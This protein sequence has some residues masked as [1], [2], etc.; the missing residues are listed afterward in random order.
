MTISN[1]DEKFQELAS[2]LGGEFYTDTVQRLLYATDASIFREVPLAIACPRT[3]EDLK[4]LIGFASENELSLIPRAAGTSLAG[5]VVGSGIVVDI[6]R[7]FNRILDFNPE[8]RWVDVEPGVVLDELNLFLKPHGLF[9]GPETSTSNRC[10]IGGMVA[11]N[12]CGAHSIIYGSTREH[13]LEVEAI[14]SD[15]SEARFKEL[16][17]NE[18]IEKR[19][20]NNLEGTIYRH[21]LELLSEPRNQESIRE[22]YPDP[23]VK[24]RNTGYALDLLLDTQP[25]DKSDKPFN[26]SALIAGSEGTLAFITSVR[27]NLVPLPPPVKGLVCPHFVSRE[28]AF[29]ANLIALTYKPG[30][31]EMMDHFILDC[32]KENLEQQRNRF[33]IKGDPAAVLIIEF[34][35]HSDVELARQMGQMEEEMR[36]A[37][38]GYHFPRIFGSDMEKVWDLRRAGLGVL[39]N[40]EGD[41]RPVSLIEDTA[42]NPVVLPSYMREFEEILARYDKECVYHAHIGSGEL[43]LRPVLNLRDPAEVEIAHQLGREVALLV[44]KYRGSLSGEHGD[45]RLRGEFIP[46]VLGERNYDLLRSVKHVFDPKNIFNPGKIIDTPS[47]KESLRVVP[48]TVPREICTY[49]RFDDEDGILRAVEKCNGSGD[50]RK[51]EL[52]GGTMCPSFM[53]TRD[54]NTTTRARANL[55]REFLSHSEKKNPF[56]HKELYDILDLCLSCKGCKSECP[57][58]V[59][60]AK[61][62]SEFLQNWYEVHGIPL[63][64]RLVAGIRRINQL[65]S[66]FPWAYNRMVTWSLSS[67]MFKKL[68][69]F[70]EIRSLPTLSGQTV[71]RWSKKHLSSYQPDHPIN[72]V[73]FFI[74]EFTNYQDAEIGIKAIKLLCRL[75][76][77]VAI[78]PVW[79]SGR[80]HLSKGFLKTARKIA[81]GNLRLLNDK[82]SPSS[83]LV[84][85][86]PSAILSFRDEYPDL[87]SSKDAGLAKEIS[88]AAFTIEEFLAAEVSKGHVTEEFFTS[89]PARILVHGHCQQKALVSSAPM[90]QILNLPENYLAEEIKSGCCGM[91][92]SFGYEKEHYD[93]SMKIGELV[94]FPSV[95]AAGLET[96]IAAPGTSCRHQILDGTGRK[97][98]HPVEIL[99]DALRVK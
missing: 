95:R 92:G 20:G 43:H 84:G 67:R 13:T 97:A 36:A 64:S 33:F 72:K 44:K 48:G 8:E 98:L 61:L 41:A 77:E 68:A 88:R 89:E 30:A 99:Y 2:Q 4:L 54:E 35:G 42:V 7:H 79:D 65:G 83:P 27:L 45:G 25:F 23:E 71:R 6:S 18:L 60:M 46:L 57:S 19:R 29:Y 37:G 62:K 85:L 70:A 12:S 32:T 90:L 80:A 11:N 38:L 34:A 76:Y 59:D 69:G 82:L 40:L 28:D 66:L 3:K 58:N 26:L 17:A 87:V 52:M 1:L 81:S 63:R 14:L 21:V 5:Q 31:V 50:C 47:L 91:A 78:P 94:L 56:D 10:M 15:G 51:S 16:S 75:G 22:G 93:L 74:D 55:L 86:E 9:F 39:S 24:R 49:F 73:W 53:A 96:L